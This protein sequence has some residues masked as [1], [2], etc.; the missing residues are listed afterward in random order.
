MG[1]DGGITKNKPYEDLWW[2]LANLL[3]LF[4]RKLGGTGS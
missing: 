2:F 3:V 4:K 1:F